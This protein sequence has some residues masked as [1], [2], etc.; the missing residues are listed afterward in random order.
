MGSVA[1]ATAQAS[2]PTRQER[3]AAETA[4]LVEAR[5]A[6]PRLKA[7]AAY[8]VKDNTVDV[9]ISEYAGYA[10]LIV[11]NGGLAPNE[12]S[13]FFKDHGFKVRLTLSEEDSWS[14]LNSGRMA[15]SVTTADVLP[16][17]GQQLQAVVPALIGFSR[18]ADGIV[19]RAN[20]KTL[21]DLKG[22]TLATAQ[23]NEADFLIRDRKSV[24]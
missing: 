4:A 11:A 17:Y 16:L 1:V 22:K 7:A 20:I 8:E 10:G 21:N 23:F 18:G 14:G 6:V 15:A 13:V 19:V 24:V 3:M 9:D 2:L 5:T 12:N